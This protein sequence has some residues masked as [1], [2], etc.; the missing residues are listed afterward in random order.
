MLKEFPLTN[1]SSIKISLPKGKYYLGSPEYA[2]KE[3]SL[4]Y[5]VLINEEFETKG[6]AKVG[7][8]VIYA[9]PITNQPHASLIGIIPEESVRK[10][11]SEEVLKFL[12]KNNYNEVG[13]WVDFDKDFIVMFEMD[14]SKTNFLSHRFG[15]N[16]S[17]NPFTGL[18]HLDSK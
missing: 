13:R 9:Y 16:I 18:D 14:K 3:Q 2:V 5:D 4:W 6:F 12:D 8:L 11:A 17:I 7:D 1:I 15:N 10:Y